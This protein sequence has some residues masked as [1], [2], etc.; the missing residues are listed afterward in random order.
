MRRM[1]TASHVGQEGKQLVRENAEVVR[2]AAKIGLLA[3]GLVWMT[4]GVLAIRLAM[5]HGDKQADRTGAL[6][7]V[8][9]KPFGKFMLVVIAIAFAAYALYNVIEAAFD[10][11][12]KGVGGRLLRLAR[13][14]L[15][16][17]FAWT[18]YRFAVA[19]QLQDSNKQS[20]DFTAKLM[21]KPMGPLLVGIVGAI[22][23]AIGLYNGR[24][25]FGR[26]YEERL[27]TFELSPANEKAV[28]VVA[29]VGYVCRGAVFA[30]VGVLFIQAALAH[31]ANKASGLDGAL[32][33]LL[34]TGYGRPLVAALGLG[35]IAFGLFSFV[36]SKYRRIDT[37]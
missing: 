32:R 24:Q 9:D 17:Y 7:A 36:E 33:R 21:Q 23:I 6:Q 12:D 4:I 19:S 3:R 27:K 28:G 2:A 31:N 5:G 20:V 13:T 14:I 11:E 29:R 10:F 1:T 22:L 25:A 37:S 16:G 26:R 18:A 8:G 15:Y 34:A 35:L 30:V